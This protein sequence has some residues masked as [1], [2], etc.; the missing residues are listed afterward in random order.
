MSSVYEAL[1]RARQANQPRGPIRSEADAGHAV[2]GAIPLRP[3]QPQARPQPERPRP[4]AP[5]P[6]SLA[7]SPKASALGPLLAALR[8]LLDG[9][10]GVV[11]QFVAATAGEGAS[12]IAR[13]FAF[14]AATAGRRR[15]LLI[16][17]DRAQL[18][19]GRALGCS[20]GQG[21]VDCLWHGADEA[22]VLRPVS[23]T[24]LSVA[25]L[26]GE[27]GPAAADAATIHEI[28][29]G[30]RGHFDVTVVDCPPV[31][32]GAFAQLLPNAADG[33]VLV[34]EAERTRPAVVLHAKGLVEQAGGTIIGAVLN[35]R[36]NYIPERL[37]RL[38]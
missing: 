6:V 28:Y 36:N 13:E 26:I 5:S 8:P 10:Q 32:G 11:L 22:D 3:R 19:I 2:N 9:D 38:L 24:L 17:G 21:L 37:Y 31:T 12:T 33:V 20:T 34:V 7:P 29:D 18:T 23:G 35:K 30:V 14:L 15:T 16:D 27:R 25:C 1:Q 4:E